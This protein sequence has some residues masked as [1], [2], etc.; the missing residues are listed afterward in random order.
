MKN[1]G[2]VGTGKNNMYSF[3]VS[4]K[5]MKTLHVDDINKNHNKSLLPPGPGAYETKKT[6]GVDGN[7]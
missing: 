3:G 4:R 2:H 6:F 1:V 5:D 7:F